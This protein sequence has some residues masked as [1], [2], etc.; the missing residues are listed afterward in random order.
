M[1][2][3]QQ[4]LD[5]S[6]L[7]VLI[8]DDTQANRALV[9][10]YLV[11]LGFAVLM[12]VNGEEAVDVFRRERPDIVLMDVM[13]PVMDGLEATRRLRAEVCDRWVPIVMLSALGGES[14][15]IAGLNVGADDY[16]VKPLSYQTFAAKMRSVARSLSFQSQRN[17]A[18]EQLRAVSEAMSDAL[19][20]FD[21]QG[22][23]LSVN[24]ALSALFGRGP[25]Q[26]FGHSLY[27]FLTPAGASCLAQDIEV[28]LADSGGALAVPRVRELEI[29]GWA[30]RPVP[31]E[32]ALSQLPAQ[33]RD[34]VFLAVLRDISERKRSER[35]LARYTQQLQH[36]HDEAERE[37]ALA[38][39][40]LE[41]QLRRGGLDDPRLRH[42]VMPAQRFSGDLVLAASAPDGRLFAMLADATGHGLGAAVSVLPAVAEFYRLVA[43]GP[44]LA[45]LVQALNQTLLESL[46]L[47]RFV[48]AAVACLDS[49]KG[50]A[51]VWVG[52]IP[53]VLHLDVCGK[54]LSRLR[55]DHLPLGIEAL[56][57]AEAAPQCV[58]LAA[59]E[60]LMLF[61]DGLLEAGSEEGEALGYAGVLD[62][63]NGRSRDELLGAIDAVVARQCSG[64][65]PHDDISVLL[66]GADFPR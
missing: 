16:L 49:E 32:L 40:V 42:C 54:L 59:G 26:F 63:M 23:I 9:R 56:S 11:R 57:H 12:A 45:E 31:V 35:E 3:A 7:R 18:L 5:Y 41:R 61:S 60:Q 27:D 65:R 29:M 48:A 19:V 34:I 38:L 39:A 33:D 44:D 6:G 14:D 52:G 2:D 50:G 22:M 28:W 15:V 64:L 20:T 58:Q 62:A 55:S 37:N 36:Y 13:M 46:P 1:T 43:T 47:G 51:K 30:G 17:Q 8:A 21:A 53:D 10:A 4:D 66:L 25:A 24:P